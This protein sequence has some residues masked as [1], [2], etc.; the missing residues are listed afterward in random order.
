MT[1]AVLAS[2]LMILESKCLPRHPQPPAKALSQICWKYLEISDCKSV[3]FA[4]CMKLQDGLCVFS[5]CFAQKTFMSWDRQSCT[6]AFCPI[7]HVSHRELPN[8]MCSPGLP[9]GVS[10]AEASVQVT[11]RI[12]RHIFW[13]SVD[14][15]P[16]KW[17]LRACGK[18]HT[19]IP[20][21]SKDVCGAFS[22]VNLKL[23]MLAQAWSEI[24]WA[25]SKW[26][27]CSLITWPKAGYQLCLDPSNLHQSYPFCCKIR[28]CSL[29]VT[30]QWAVLG[31]TN[32]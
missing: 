6:Q 23:A 30:A 25:A 15:A 14:S 22:D 29:L 4:V 11:K 32:P 17:C 26:Y 3:W 28:T 27:W 18:G 16:Q 9:L 5:F 10:K 19:K 2:A 8:G 31:R 12:H 13:V 1:I 20:F 24:I 7:P 21:L